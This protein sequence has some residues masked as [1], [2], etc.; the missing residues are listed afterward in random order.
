MFKDAGILGIIAIVVI[1]V[2][3]YGSLEEWTAFPIF[4]AAIALGGILLALAFRPLQRVSKQLEKHK[5]ALQELESLLKKDNLEYTTDVRV[6]R[7]QK[8]EYIIKKSI[9]LTTVNS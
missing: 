6:S 7:D 5:K 8:G 2:G 3:A 9:K 4:Q 1:G